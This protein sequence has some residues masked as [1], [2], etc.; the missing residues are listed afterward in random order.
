MT[1]GREEAKTYI[2]EKLTPNTVP[3]GR[4]HRPDCDLDT[5]HIGHCVKL[6]DDGTRPALPESASPLPTDAQARKDIPIVRGLLDYFPAACAA[7]AELSRIGNEQHN[8]GEE[9]HWARGKSS[10]HAD[11]AVRHLMERGTVDTDKVRHSAKAAWRAL[12]NLQ[13]ELEEAGAP[14]ARGAK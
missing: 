1:M 4:A 2:T 10:D 3:F 5:D 7:V 14:I 11:C 6:P 13:I 12:A 8:P 9:M